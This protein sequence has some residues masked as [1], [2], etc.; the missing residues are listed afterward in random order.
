LASIQKQHKQ[1][2]STLRIKLENVKKLYL[3]NTK[4]NYDEC[5]KLAVDLFQDVFNHQIKQLLSA[6]PLDH[7]IEDTGKLFWSGLKRAPTPLDLD[8]ND[9]IHVELVQAA[10]N[11]Y[12][13]MFNI[14]LVRNAQHVVEI[15][16]KVPL[17][18]FVPK[19]GVKIETDEKKKTEDQPV[20]T[21]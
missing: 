21:D 10:A 5:V 19:Q 9:K 4:K 7:I 6:F 12:A 17:Q 14:P 1:N 2:P 20:Y 16:K 8:L 3:A 13:F 15:A 11:I 18:P